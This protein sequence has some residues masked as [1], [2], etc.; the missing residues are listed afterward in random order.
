[1]QIFGAIQLELLRS[2]RNFRLSE[3]W[4]K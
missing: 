1:M 4:R 2:Y 3:A